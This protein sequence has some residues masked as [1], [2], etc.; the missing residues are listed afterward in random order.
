MDQNLIFDIGTNTGEDTGYYLNKGFRVVAVEAS[1]SIVEQL[2]VN[3][4]GP[5][6]SGALVVVNQ[7]IQPQ[8]GSFTFYRN[9]DNDHWSSFERAY[10]TRQGTRYEELQIPCTTIAALLQQFGCPR[11]MKIDVEG[12]DQGILQAM[13]ASTEKPAFTSVEEYGAGTLRDLQALGYEAFFISPQRD[14]SWVSL[15]DPSRE[16][17]RVVKPFNGYDSGPFGLDLP[18][19]GWMPFDKAYE[20]FTTKIRNE[21]WEYIGP[22][23]EWHDIHATTFRELDRS[24]YP[25][26]SWRS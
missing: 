10:G 23:H 20:H 21:K 8:P 15:P 9:L 18:R 5:I 14:K 19:D 26:S 17:S 16:G 25:T 24:Q 7:G 22:E 2:R 11:Y 4:A 6:A 12:A 3:F 13:Q 1:P